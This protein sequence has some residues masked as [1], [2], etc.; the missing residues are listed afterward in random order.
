MGNAVAKVFIFMIAI[1]TS[2]LSSWNWVILSY[3][4]WINFIVLKSSQHSESQLYVSW[5]VFS[6]THLK[7]Q[8]TIKILDSRTEHSEQLKH[9]LQ[10][11][12]ISNIWS[13][14]LWLNQLEEIAPFRF[15]EAFF[16]QYSAS[17]EVNILLA[18]AGISKTSVIHNLNC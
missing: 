14:I 8:T 3:W 11:L 16:R 2:V 18:E 13:T 6:E 9:L 4:K 10:I 12:V 1:K 5:K 17:P 15:S 7:T